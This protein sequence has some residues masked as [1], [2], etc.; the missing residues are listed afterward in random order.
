M[1]FSNQKKKN[2]ILLYDNCGVLR[3]EFP[4]ETAGYNAE[5]IYD[6]LVYS[7]TSDQF[8]Q[9]NS[10]G[11][12][13]GVLKMPSYKQ[14]GEFAYDGSGSI[15]VLADKVSTKEKAGCVVKLS[16][17]G[18]EVT[19]ALDMK[20]IGKLKPVYNASKKK[21]DWIGLDSIQVVG[22]NQLLLS[23]SR[24]SSIFI[25]F[26]YISIPYFTIIKIYRFIR[27]SHI[28]YFLLI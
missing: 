15:Y 28:R 8:A 18:G 10:L 23:S 17:T 5:F 26:I 2:A 4:V 27:I 3:G 22:V 16:V 6:N 7:I 20:N 9:V 25:T 11:Q 1:V 13:T 19:E 12:V 21:K 24:Y 14:C